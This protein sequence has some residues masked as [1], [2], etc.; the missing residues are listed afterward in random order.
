[1]TYQSNQKLNNL[2]ESEMFLYESESKSQNSLVENVLQILIRS[3]ISVMIV[4][5]DLNKA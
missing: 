1:M 3:K 2:L 5:M 4:K